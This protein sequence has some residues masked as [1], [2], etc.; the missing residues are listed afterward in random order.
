MNPS[1]PSRML[2]ESRAE[3]RPQSAAFSTVAEAM[4]AAGILFR[5]QAVGQSMYPTILNGE[6]LHV[7]PGDKHKLRAGDIVFFRSNREF[8]AHRIVRTKGDKFIMRGD[9]S[10]QDDA[11]VDRTQILGR[12]IAKEC[13]ETGKLVDLAGPRA[14]FTFR[15]RRFRSS[16]R[17]CLKGRISRKNPGRALGARSTADSQSIDDSGNLPLVFR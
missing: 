15:F 4:A 16:M 6:M 5:F 9:A 7:E 13:A 14:R 10:P 12:V 1:L 8:K 11:A 17:R 3:D 2:A